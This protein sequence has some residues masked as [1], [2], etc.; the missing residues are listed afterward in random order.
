MKILTAAFLSLFS[1]GCVASSIECPA[2]SELQ[3]LFKFDRIIQ[4]NVSN[5]KYIVGTTDFL[6]HGTRWSAAGF[7]NDVDS[8]VDAISV[9]NDRLSSL[10]APEKTDLGVQTTCDY[11]LANSSFRVT[12][13][14]SIYH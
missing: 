13:F 1:M 5:S 7:I 3:S 11:A 6:A 2:S 9:S 14:S 12:L 4:P 8:A 10:S